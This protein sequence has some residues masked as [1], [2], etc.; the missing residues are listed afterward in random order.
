MNKGRTLGLMQATMQLSFLNQSASDTIN[1]AFMLQVRHLC[2]NVSDGLSTL[3]LVR[4]CV[5]CSCLCVSFCVC[6]HS[7]ALVY[8][9]VSVLL[10]HPQVKQ[11]ESD[12]LGA[13]VGVDYDVQLKCDGRVRAQ[14]RVDGTQKEH[15]LQ[16]SKLKPGIHTFQTR[17]RAIDV[18]KWSP[19]SALL[20]VTI[21]ENSIVNFV[22]NV[23]FSSDVRPTFEDDP[24]V[25]VHSNVIVMNRSRDA[26]CQSRSTQGVSGLR[27]HHHNTSWETQNPDS[28]EEENL[29]QVPFGV[30]VSPRTQVSGNPASA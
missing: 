1:L 22:A 29:Q 24:T 23:P 14:H 11:A 12:G 18:Y 26:S 4:F 16:I 10:D 28:R 2:L 30:I 25:G 3:L 7:I 15:V 6:R 20:P 9:P 27:A 13:V 17:V 5:F 8:V 19:W 21:N